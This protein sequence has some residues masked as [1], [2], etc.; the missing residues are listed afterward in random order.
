TDTVVFVASGKQ[1]EDDVDT[2]LNIQRVMSPT[3]VFEVLFYVSLQKYSFD[4]SVA[5]ATSANGRTM[6]WVSNVSHAGDKKILSYA[7]MMLREK[8]KLAC[9]SRENS[10]YRGEYSGVRC[11]IGRENE[12]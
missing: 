8:Y 6:F 5:N 10:T 7:K 3:H 1:A 12:K 11:D 9:R 2:M 4:L